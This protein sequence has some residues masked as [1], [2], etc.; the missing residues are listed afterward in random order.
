M[1]A[2]FDVSRLFTC[3]VVL[4]IY[5][6]TI[7]EHETGEARE[8]IQS[9]PLSCPGALTYLTELKDRKDNCTSAE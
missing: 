3:L 8:G 9:E 5:L 1:S 4:G 6:I 7:L 2:C